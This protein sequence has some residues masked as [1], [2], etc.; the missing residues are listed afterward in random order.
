MECLR[1]GPID[2]K[3]QMSLSRTCEIKK[4]VDKE[5]FLKSFSLKLEPVRQYL[6]QFT[7]YYWNGV[8][9]NQIISSP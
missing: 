2:N 4:F 7:G 1:F 9:Q 5:L 3:N 8:E 6:S